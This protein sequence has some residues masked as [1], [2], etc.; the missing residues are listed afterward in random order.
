MPRSERLPGMLGRDNDY[1][2]WY[3]QLKQ[4]P[5]LAR[6]IGRHLAA[7]DLM[8]ADEEKKVWAV[9][10]NTVLAPRQDA[11]EKREEKRHKKIERKEAAQREWT[12]SSPF[13][14]AK[15]HFRETVDK[16]GIAWNAFKE[17]VNDYRVGHSTQKAVKPFLKQLETSVEEFVKRAQ[18]LLG[19]M[20]A[21]ANEAASS[22]VPGSPRVVNERVYNARFFCCCTV[23][24]SVVLNQKLKIVQDTLRR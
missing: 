2:R 22:R 16:T 18:D 8:E 4:G 5:G 3:H 12:Q 15:A 21:S 6:I 24:Y 13:A 9:Y 20:I 19:F 7:H 1:L 11:R 14:R 10:Q 17:K 23:I